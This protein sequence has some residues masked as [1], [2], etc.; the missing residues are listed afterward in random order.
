MGNNI[1]PVCGYPNLDQ[2]AWDPDTGSPSFDICP[3]CGCEFGYQDATPTAKEKYRKNWVKQG[4]PWFKPE[5]KPPE[6]SL[7]DQLKQIGVDLEELI[8]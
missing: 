1:C 2:P 3:S 8:Q 5:L 6:W 7:K 4:A